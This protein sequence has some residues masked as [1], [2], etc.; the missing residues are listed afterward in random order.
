[1]STATATTD[2]LAKL[3]ALGMERTLTPESY[4]NIAEAGFNRATLATA[5]GLCQ[6]IVEL[7]PLGVRS[8]MYRAQAAGIIPDTSHK[9]YQL[10]GRLILKLRRAGIVNY[11]WI[12]DSTRRRLKPSSWANISDFADEAAELYRRNLWSQQADYVEVFCE[13]DAMA[14][15]LGTVTSEFD[16]HLNIIRGQVSETFVWEIAEQWNQI[17]KPIHAYYLGDHDPAGLQ[18]EASLKS[19]LAGFCSKP[20]HWKRLAITPEDFANQELR[21][22]CVKKGAAGRIEY[23]RRHGDRCVEVDAISPDEIRGRVRDAIE[24]HI[25]K[26]EWERLQEIEQEEQETIRGICIKMGGKAA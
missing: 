18:I 12:V 6:L 14:G 2:A 26:G 10:V 4:Q 20:F 16:I 11:R 7:K 13:K 3:K 1:M 24:G 9:Y 22:F 17:A 15:V 5:F 8:C 21:G 23:I 19:K 25:A